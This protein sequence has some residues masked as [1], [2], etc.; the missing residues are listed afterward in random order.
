MIWEPTTDDHEELQARLEFLKAV[1]KALAGLKYP[2]ETNIVGEFMKIAQGDREF[3]L[4]VLSAVALG[5]DPVRVREL[6]LDRAPP[7]LFAK[8]LEALS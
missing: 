6:L 5:A 1:N 8:V 2:N 3:M 7:E 4:A